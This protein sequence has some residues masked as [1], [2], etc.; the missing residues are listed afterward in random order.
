VALAQPI[1]RKENIALCLVGLGGVAG[2]VGQG[3]CGARLLSAAESLYDT[4]GLSW[5]EARA[6]FERYMAAA[7]AQLDE[8]TFAAAWAEGRAL[9]LEQAVT[10]ALNVAV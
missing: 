3:E 5:P 9:S 10:E 4:I 1:Q 2:A 6:D 8:A 7:R